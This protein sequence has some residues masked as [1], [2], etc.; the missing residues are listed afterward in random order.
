MIIIYWWGSRFTEIKGVVLEA[1]AISLDESTNVLIFLLVQGSLLEAVRV[2]GAQKLGEEESVEDV[3]VDILVLGVFSEII[4]S[5]VDIAVAMLARHVLTIEQLLV[6]EM[7]LGLKVALEVL[8]LLTLGDK[9]I[10]FGG[11]GRALLLDGRAL[12]EV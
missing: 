8:T 11:V 3:L 7:L 6:K 9:S 12:V 5:Y 4:G 10:V 1:E 2:L